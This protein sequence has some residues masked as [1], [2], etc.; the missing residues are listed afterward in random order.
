VSRRRVVYIVL[1]VVAV[2]A[3]AISSLAAIPS[4]GSKGAQLP[5][6]YSATTLEPVLQRL[7]PD[8]LAPKNVID[9]VLAPVGYSVV[10]TANLNLYGST[11][12]RYVD[13][14]VSLPPAK[15]TKFYEAALPDEGW[16]IQK[17]QP[18]S[19]GDEVVA[20]RAGDDGFYWEVGIKDPIGRISAGSLFQVR[21]IQISFS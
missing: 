21:L 20:S 19:G 13:M 11:F 15:V 14:K 5:I 7:A 10:K 6:P 3:V 12:D 8:G 16:S 18:I 2:V 4:G 17:V 1:G 9:S